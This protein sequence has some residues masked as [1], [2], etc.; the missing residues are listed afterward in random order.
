MKSLP[1]VNR[2]SAYSSPIPPVEKIGDD[3]FYELECADG[4]GWANQIFFVGPI[5]LEVGTDVLITAPGV[6]NSTEART[7]SADDTEE[8]APEGEIEGTAVDADDSQ[9]A[10]VVPLT[11]NPEP[12]TL[13][14]QAAECRDATVTTIDDYTGAGDVLYAQVECDGV[15]GWL[16]STTLF[17]PVEYAVGDTVSL[18]E[19]ALIGFNLR[20]I[21]LSISLFDIEG[22]SGGSS[23]VAGECAFD[24][25]ELTPVDAQLMDVG[26]Y[27]S[28]TGNIVGVFYR[29]ACSNPDGELIEG[30]INQD[31]IGE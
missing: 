30:W 11:T 16:D 22:P 8:T 14:N 12:L 29:A 23:V 4:V 5:P 2:A 6:T 9:L 27:R 18:G 7:E 20:G 24:F 17:G 10:E 31:R 21:F 1:P 15:M 25:D 28:S 13:D 26:Y 3:L 19:K